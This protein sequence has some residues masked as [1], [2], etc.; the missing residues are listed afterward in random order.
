MSE[1]HYRCLA[2]DLRGLLLLHGVEFE[3]HPISLVTLE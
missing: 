2:D 3:A 1:L